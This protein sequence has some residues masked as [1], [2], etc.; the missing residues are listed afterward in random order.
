[1]IC[2][3]ALACAAASAKTTGRD[4]VRLDRTATPTELAKY[5]SEMVVKSEAA[6]D[7]AY[8]SRVEYRSDDRALSVA[9]WRSGPGVL[10]TGGYPHDEYCLVLEGHLVVTNRSGHREGFGPGDTFVIPKGWAGT[11]NMTTSTSHS[12]RCRERRAES[13]VRPRERSPIN[14]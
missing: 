9:L 3:L 6:F 11:W 1:M 12:R 7:G 8:T 13:A 5:P 14:P 2:A 4:I 10:Q